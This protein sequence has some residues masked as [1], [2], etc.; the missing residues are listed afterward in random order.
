MQEGH[1]CCPLGVAHGAPGLEMVLPPSPQ[2][3]GSVPGSALGASGTVPWASAALLWGP[4]VKTYVDGWGP[5]AAACGGPLGTL[6]GAASPAGLLVSLLNVLIA[7]FQLEQ[8]LSKK[9]EEVEGNQAILRYRRRLLREA[10]FVLTV[11]FCH[12]R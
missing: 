9:L 6:E 10:G 1:C 12:V 7:L 8:V 4:V 11:C 3:L 2:P 5:W